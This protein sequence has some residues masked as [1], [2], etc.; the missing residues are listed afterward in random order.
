MAVSVEQLNQWGATMQYA[1]GS[2]PVPG[3]YGVPEQWPHIRKLYE[4][5]GFRAEGP[6][7]IIYLASVDELPHPGEPPLDEVV[8]RRSVGING[9]RLSAARGDERTGSSRSGR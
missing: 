8:L 7:E 2:L 5:A 6:T 1:D 4:R 3:V 9:N